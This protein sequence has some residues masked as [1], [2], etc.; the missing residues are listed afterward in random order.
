MLLFTFD[1]GPGILVFI[2]G[3]VY[4]PSSSHDLTKKE[5]E[6]ARYDCHAYRSL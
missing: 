4:E 5:Y 3:L 6:L 2:I 1:L